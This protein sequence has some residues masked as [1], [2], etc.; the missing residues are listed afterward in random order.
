[1]WLAHS[2]LSQPNTRK[3]LRDLFLCPCI[4]LLSISRSFFV[5]SQSGST[6]NAFLCSFYPFKWKFLW[7]FSRCAVSQSLARIRCLCS[8]LQMTL[9]LFHSA[10]IPCKHWQHWLQVTA[11]SVTSGDSRPLPSSPHPQGHET[12]TVFHHSPFHGNKSMLAAGLSMQR[13]ARARQGATPCPWLG[14]ELMMDGN[15]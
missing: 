2:K 7:L 4:G 5:Q 3:R 14:L 11:L 9:W 13:A 10:F 6:R 12:P 15:I 1:M 8:L